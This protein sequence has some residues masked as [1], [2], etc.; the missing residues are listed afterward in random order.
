MDAETIIYMG[1]IIASLLAGLLFGVWKK[2]FVAGQKKAVSMAITG[3]VFVLIFLMG[4][5]TGL[6]RGVMDN[7]G[8][9]GVSALLLA[10]GAIAGSLVFVVVFDRLFL[11][12]VP[13]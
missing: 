7:L 9:Y 6:N 10:L 12:G 8:N 1:L 3:L 5:K 4:L 2:N 11:R 13:K